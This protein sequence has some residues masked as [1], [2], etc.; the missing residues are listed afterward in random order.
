MI[1]YPKEK[2]IQ[3][4]FLMILVVVD[5]LPNRIQAVEAETPN[6]YY[7]EMQLSPGDTQF[8]LSYLP[9]M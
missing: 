2:E 1:F 8:I 6:E 5:R 4:L 3:G 9:V 7:Y